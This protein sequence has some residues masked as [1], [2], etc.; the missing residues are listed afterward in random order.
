MINISIINASTVVTDEDAAT[1]VAALKIQVSRDFFLA[2]GIDA[3][4]T[5]VPKGGT[6]AVGD[7]QVVV[8]DNSDQADA[9]GYHDITTEG[10]PIGKIFAK[11]DI[12]A[13]MSWSVT[14]SHEILE[15]IGD[16]DI[17]LTALVQDA[18]GGGRLYSYET[19]D[20]CED[21]SLGYKIGDVLV[22][23]FVFPSW[24]ESFWAPGAT[25]FDQQSKVTAPFQ[26]LPGGY[27]GY[28]DIN[29]TNGWQQLT[30]DKS[31]MT[32]RKS[33]PPIG[34]RRNRRSV[35]RNQWVRSTK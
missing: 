32:L 29:I 14:A 12:D 24:F 19:C 2:W 35:P 26:L 20:A 11:S 21:D 3:K 8:L 22:S 7:W 15:M 6:P 9:L 10:L 23:D 1:V 18:S 16:P 34:S 25:Q 27:I 4:L 30:A 31:A 28:M 13:G 5:F 17:N 33:R